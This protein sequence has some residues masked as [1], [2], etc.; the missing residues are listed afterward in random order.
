MILKTLQ[1]ILL[2]VLLLQS[3]ISDAKET[4]SPNSSAPLANEMKVLTPASMPSSP[5]PGENFT[6]SVQV[7]MLAQGQDPSTLGSASVTFQPSARAAWHT[8][9]KGQLLVVTEGAG[10]IQEVGKPIRK[11]K[12]G[13]VIWTPPGVK[14]WHGANTVSSMTHIAIQESLNGSPVKWMEKVT[15]HEYSQKE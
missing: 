7:T 12:K 13:D 3:Y 2:P 10:L 9:P 6:G 15:D 11:I 8:H 4:R 1:N 14:H 5:G